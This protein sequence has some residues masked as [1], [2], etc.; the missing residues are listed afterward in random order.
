MEEN[1]EVLSPVVKFL[2]ELA[3][4]EE[5]KMLNLITQRERKTKWIAH[6]VRHEILLLTVL[7]LAEIII[8][9]KISD[10]RRPHGMDIG[11]YEEMKSLAEYRLK[12]RGIE[13]ICDV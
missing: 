7:C 8:E 11:A 6:S 3:T 13:Y 5:R 4:S 10:V 1:V 9:E 2:T 12:W